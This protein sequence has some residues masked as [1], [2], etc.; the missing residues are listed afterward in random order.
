M[1]EYADLGDHSEDERIVIIAAAAMT[2]AVVAF[3]VDDDAAADRYVA[4]LTR[5]PGVRVLGR[6]PGPVTNTIVVRVGP[7][8]H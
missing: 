2:G 1:T 6:G 7:Q 3:V 5:L 8:Q 4:K